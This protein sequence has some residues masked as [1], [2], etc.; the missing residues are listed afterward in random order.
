[1]GT[2][3]P[4]VFFECRIIEQ[5]LHF[6]TGALGDGFGDFIGPIGPI[7]RSGFDR[8]YATDGTYQKACLP[9]ADAL[10]FIPSLAITRPLHCE[11]THAQGVNYRSL[12]GERARIG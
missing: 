4:L 12:T 6:N 3:G 10:Q 1:M 5:V 8:T 11:L 9:L 2:F 7:C